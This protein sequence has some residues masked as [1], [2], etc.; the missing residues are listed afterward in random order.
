MKSMRASALTK[1]LALAT[2]LTGCSVPTV[3][4]MTYYRLP[5][6]AESLVTKV[7]PLALPVD[8]SVFAADGL[9]AEQALIYALDE[10]GRTLR[11]YHYQVWA[12]P[13]AR[14][15]QRRLIALLARSNATPQVSD[16]LPASTDALRIGGLILRFDRLRQIAGY[17]AAVTLQLRV[18]RGKSLLHERVYR[19]EALA[20]GTEVAASVDAFGAAI[21]IIYA[22]F[23]DDLARLP[24]VPTP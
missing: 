1:L 14:L 7:P 15:L 3:P 9:Y 23:L 21:D 6:L 2:A 24:Q 18:E 8:V 22:Q 13:P 20:S 4:D 10:G 16:R 11:S 19:A 17:S 5:P 12:D